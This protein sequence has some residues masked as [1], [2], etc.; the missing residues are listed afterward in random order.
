M[1]KLDAEL[2]LINPERSL[3]EVAA[4]FTDGSTIQAASAVAGLDEDRALELSEAL[5]RHSPVIGGFCPA[6]SAD[7]T[8]RLAPARRVELSNAPP[9]HRPPGSSYPKC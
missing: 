5:A 8:F 4:V 7:T 6:R 1:K 9:G 2:V 3:L